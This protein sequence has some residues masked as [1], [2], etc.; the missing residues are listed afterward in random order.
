MPRYTIALVL[1]ACFSLGLPLYGMQANKH[2]PRDVHGCSGQC[3]SDWKAQTGGILALQA[4]AAEAK[5]EASPAEL[6]RSTYTGC[7]AC[8][9]AN[10]EGGIGPQLAGQSA[11]DIADKLRRYKAGATL[12]G[13]SNLMWSQ[14][15]MLS[16]RDIDNISAFVE[17]L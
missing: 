9:G 15:G 14:A 13:Q 16:D 4:A 10:G 5:A 12:G 7:I 11:A 6:G 2:S 8:H 17:T 3:Y 1:F